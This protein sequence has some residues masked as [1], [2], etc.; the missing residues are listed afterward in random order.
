MKG[1]PRKLDEQTLQ[2]IEQMNTHP[3]NQKTPLKELFFDVAV[4][5][6]KRQLYR[7]IHFRFD[8]R[9]IFFIRHAKVMEEILFT[10][11]SEVHHDANVKL[12]YVSLNGVSKHHSI[13][14]QTDNDFIQIYGILRDIS[15]NPKKTFYKE[16][17]E[18]DYV[19][20]KL[21][22]EVYKRG[23]EEW[24]KR[25]L[26]LYNGLF[27]LYGKEPLPLNLCPIEAK[28]VIFFHVKNIVEI[29]NPIRKI[30]F[31]FKSETDFNA[32]RQALLTCEQYQRNPVMIKVKDFFSGKL[33]FL[34]Q[35]CREVCM[36]N[37]LN[38]EECAEQFPLLC[39]VMR[40]VTKRKQVT[41]GSKREII[42]QE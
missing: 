27:M 41:E 14:T 4:T 35:H 39:E 24:A 13:I 7:I 40:S 20:K 30:L 42:E 9:K 12:S 17:F 23:Q 6:D 18:Q 22:L 5:F 21:E 37:K 32:F 36:N 29:R 16:D 19:L 38:P 26:V 1:N 34:V 8:I 28:T 31:Y 3:Q 10:S 33:A 15:I 11:V 25:R 2:L